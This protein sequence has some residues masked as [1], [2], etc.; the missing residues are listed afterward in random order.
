MFCPIRW[1]RQRRRRHHHPKP[2]PTPVPSGIVDTT[3]SEIISGRFRSATDKHGTNGTLV[4]VSGLRVVS[5]SLE[6]DGDTHVI[7]TDGTVE[8]FVTEITSVEK[9]KGIVDPRPGEVIEEIGYP[10]Y[11]TAHA[12]EAW[13]GNTGWEIH[14]IIGWK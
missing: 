12:S 11:D 6:A 8:T 3:L 13:H 5:T 14:P 1:F 7:V 9:A 4:R 10:F 2:V